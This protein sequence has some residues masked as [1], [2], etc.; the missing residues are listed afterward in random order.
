M[1]PNARHPGHREVTGVLVADP[2]AGR[3][4]Y[5]QSVSVAVSHSLSHAVSEAPRPRTR[6][7]ARIML[8][9]M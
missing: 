8:R 6:K 2:R 9:V 5:S 7:A 1:H 3:L 4:A